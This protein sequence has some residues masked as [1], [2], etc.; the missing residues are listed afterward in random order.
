MSEPDRGRLEKSLAYMSWKYV[1][2]A[3]LAV[4]RGNQAREKEKG[5]FKASAD[6]WMSV[7][8][9]R[10]RNFEACRRH[11][12]DLTKLDVTYFPLSVDA[13][14]RLYFKVRKRNPDEVAA[15]EAEVQRAGVQPPPPGL[16]D[17]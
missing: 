2:A 11:W 9:L 4:F 12:C 1:A 15:F 10:Q 8:G 17:D 6:V 14:A 5:A 13:V 16:F 3:I 7:D